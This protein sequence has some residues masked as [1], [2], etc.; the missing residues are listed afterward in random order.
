V[1][2]VR[3]KV[4]FDA[5]FDF[6]HRLKDKEFRDRVSKATGGSLNKIV[7]VIY[8]TDGVKAV[9]ARLRGA[10]LRTGDKAL[11]AI[12]DDDAPD[13]FELSWVTVS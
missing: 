10:G 1:T 7:M 9:M 4:L 3:D 13:G 6:A 5:G 8:P 12:L 2:E 11:L